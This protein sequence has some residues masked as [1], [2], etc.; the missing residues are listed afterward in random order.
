MLERR[1]GEMAEEINR[2][3]DKL[4]EKYLLTMAEGVCIVD[5]PQLD[6][7]TIQGRANEPR[8]PLSGASRAGVNVCAPSTPTTGRSR[9]LRERR[10]I[11][12]RME[13]ALAA[14]ESE[15]HLQPK[16][17]LRWNSVA[18]AEALVRWRDRTRDCS[19]Q[20]V[21]PAF[22]EQ[23]RLH[24]LKVDLYVSLSRS[25]GC[26]VIVAGRGEK[27][28]PISVNLSRVLSA[29]PGYP[30]PVR[31]DPGQI[32][33]AARLLEFELTETVAFEN[34]EA[35]RMVLGEFHQRGYRCSLDDF[36]SGYSSL[37]MP[38][39]SEHRRH[40]AGPD[41]LA[42][43]RGRTTGGLRVQSVAGAGA[44]TENPRPSAR[45]CRAWPWQAGISAGGPAATW[46]RALP[47]PGPCRW[48]ILRI[49]LFRETCPHGADGIGV[50][51]HRQKYN[52]WSRAA[53]LLTGRPNFG[54]LN[55]SYM[56]D[57]SGITTRSIAAGSDGT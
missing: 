48:R 15:L 38:W 52:L 31:R 2:F 4:Q 56:T 34:A 25:A 20:R 10:E 13:A 19:P 27:P 47:S 29:Q 11:E 45:E 46:C 33:R 9:M 14:G 12:N 37:N 50:N 23:K 51:V 1:L 57:G 21:H 54:I 36:G 39:R 49:G 40:Q 43:R 24:R 42:P 41:L 44:Q 8:R 55:V 18:G 26:C 35:L 32:R 5:D 28:M 22:F 16:V 7:V 53:G 17:E 3:N 6:I 30:R